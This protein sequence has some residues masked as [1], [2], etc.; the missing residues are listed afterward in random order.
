MKDLGKCLQASGRSLPGFTGF[1]GIGVLVA[2]LETTYHRIWRPRPLR[3][4][5]RRAAGACG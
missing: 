3:Y 4:R 1:A 5:D 2:M